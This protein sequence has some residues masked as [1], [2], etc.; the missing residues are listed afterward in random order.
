MEDKTNIALVITESAHI[1]QVNLKVLD[2]CKNLSSKY[3]KKLLD[4]PIVDHSW[5]YNNI[6]IEY[7]KIITIC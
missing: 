1:I 4:H 6:I 5:S 7:Q 3:R 2:F